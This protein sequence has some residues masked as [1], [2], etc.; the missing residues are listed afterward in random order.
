MGLHFSAE[1][2][3]EQKLEWQGG[4]R[5]DTS[6][7]EVGFEVGDFY[8]SINKPFNINHLNAERQACI[9][10]GIMQ[11]QWQRLQAAKAVY[12]YLRYKAV[13]DG[14]TRS[15]HAALNGLT[16]P[17]DDPCWHIIYPP[18]A[19][20][21]RCSVEPLMQGKVSTDKEVN[22]AI[23]NAKI[24]P[25]FKVATMGQVFSDQNGMHI[26]DRKRH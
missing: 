6:S 10:T 18:K 21:C 1:L 17:I 8:P 3:A 13:M 7:P 12:P 22:N 2:L 23:A 14:R 20:N 9:S 4:G 24:P 19:F 16:R 11:A 26:Q 25:A 5:N 15:E